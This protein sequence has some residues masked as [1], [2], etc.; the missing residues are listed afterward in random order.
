MY[1]TTVSEI[2][3]EAG[4]PVVVIDAEAVITYVNPAFQEAYGWTSKDLVGE[5]VTKI[6]P[7]HMRDAHNFGF[8]RFLVTESPR[9]LNT[10]LQLPVYCKDGSVIDAEHFILGEQTD[11]TWR[12]AA[13][14]T[15]Q[16]GA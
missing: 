11:G 12:F 14:I 2:V 1:P 5:V 16:P 6:M 3:A 4:K 15:R 7:P 10:P 8:S 9:I 13:T